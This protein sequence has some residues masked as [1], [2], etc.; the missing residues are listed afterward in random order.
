[1]FGIFKRKKN[2]KKTKS[3]L[4]EKHTEVYKKKFPRLPDA[5]IQK[6]ASRKVEWEMDTKRLKKEDVL[7]LLKKIELP[8]IIND[9]FVENEKSKKLELD[10]FYRCPSEY[11]LMTKDE[12]DHY[13]VDTIIPFL[14]DPSFYKI[15]AYD[16]TRNGFLTFDIESPDA[17]EK[18]ERFTW[19][20]IFVSDILY[21]WECDVE[22]NRIL[23]Y[24]D[25][26]NLKWVEEILNSIENDLDNSTTASC[27]DWKNAIYTKY[28]MIIK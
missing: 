15:Y 16:T 7:S 21:W 24:G 11:F 19:D 13:N 4:I 27:T 1:M 8:T 28:N 20:G 14:S 23:E 10:D 17:I 5:D 22:K 3:N 6:M 9:L 25:T 26:L 12:Q 18:T 2:Q